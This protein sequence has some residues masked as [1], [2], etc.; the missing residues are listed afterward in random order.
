MWRVCRREP[1][2]GLSCPL[3]TVLSQGLSR[4]PDHSDLSVQA[5]GLEVGTTTEHFTQLPGLGLWPHLAE[6]VLL[7]TVLSPWPSAL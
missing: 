4:L 6:L 3:L 2:T 5:L 7:S 1:Q